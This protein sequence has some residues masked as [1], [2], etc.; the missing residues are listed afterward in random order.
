[1]EKP[2]D[3][4]VHIS[5]PFPLAVSYGYQTKTKI[6]VSSQKAM[7]ARERLAPRQEFILF[8]LGAEPSSPLFFI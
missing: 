1:M 7:V 8:S 2:L 4:K 6:Q 3:V 5:N